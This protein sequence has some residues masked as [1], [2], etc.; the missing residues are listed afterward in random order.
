[1]SF[2]SVSKTRVKRMCLDL[3]ADL[4]GI[5]SADTFSEAPP[6]FHPA[7]VLPS[8]QSVVVLACEFPREAAQG[9]AAT[10][11][12]TRNAM[13]EKMSH[14][15]S[16]AAKQIL[17][18]GFE[19]TPIM[20]LATSPDHGRFRGPISLKHAAALAGLGKIGKNTLLVNDQYGNMIW[21]SAVCTSIPLE[22][23]P[24]AKYETCSE[25]CTVCIDKCPASALGDP[26]MNQRACYA[27]AFKTIE[28]KLEI[29]CWT[30]RKICPH[31][32]GTK[33]T[34][35]PSSK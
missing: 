14:L 23:D 16:E 24:P 29:Q 34:A 17:S 21:L 5:A 8:C 4:V 7:D 32:L 19:A 22:S 11:T 33:N 30:C 2:K 12:Q 18:M 6:G 25:S 3:G 31:H 27:H 10:Y 26:L 35:A 15:A 13:S 20:P 1:M 28:G 9:D